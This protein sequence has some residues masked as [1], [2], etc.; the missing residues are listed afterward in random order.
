MGTMHGGDR[1]MGA[2]YGDDVMHGD[3][4]KFPLM[5]QRNISEA[6]TISIHLRSIYR[7]AAIT[8]NHRSPLEHIE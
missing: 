4:K 7:D 2:M 3:T 1:C 6:S 8:T 5:Q